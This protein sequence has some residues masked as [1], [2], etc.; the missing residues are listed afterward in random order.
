[1]AG[2]TPIRKS[3]ATITWCMYMYPD[4]NQQTTECHH[5][6]KFCHYLLEITHC[7]SGT[8]RSLR[9]SHTID[10][11]LKGLA[12]SNAGKGCQLHTL[13]VQDSMVHPNSLHATMLP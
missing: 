2:H 8:R 3:N 7:T 5:H 9:L 10:L 11:Y 4:M 12:G 13:S 6:N 1:M